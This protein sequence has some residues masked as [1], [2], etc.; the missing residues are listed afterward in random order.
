MGGVEEYRQRSTAKHGNF[1]FSSRQEVSLRGIAIEQTEYTLSVQH[2]YFLASESCPRLHGNANVVHAIF[3]EELQ[4]DPCSFHLHHGH[5]LCDAGGTGNFASTGQY[6]IPESE[7]WNR[8]GSH[9]C[10]SFCDPYH[11]FRLACLIFVPYL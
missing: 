7:L 4:L 1:D 5:T 3:R 2:L 8:G 9:R 6:S 11:Y 10:G